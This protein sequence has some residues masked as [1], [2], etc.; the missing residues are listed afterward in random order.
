[1]NGISV[2][3]SANE[4]LASVDQFSSRDLNRAV[5]IALNRCADG[6]RID[7]SRE[8]RSRYKVKASTVSKAF[9]IQRATASTLTA[10]VRVRGRPLNVMGFGARQTQQGVTVNI[11]GARK[12]I[13]HAFILNLQDSQGEGY[14]I[15]ASRA[16]QGGKRVGRYPLAGVTTVDVPGLFLVKD[17]NEVVR[18]SATQ[19]FDKELRGAVQAILAGR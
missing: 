19:R 18:E 6:I 3:Q 15:V 8:I 2:K 9:S 7:S 14:Q 10:V 16:I 17:L 11:K 13:A 1:M 4:F 5:A 12:L